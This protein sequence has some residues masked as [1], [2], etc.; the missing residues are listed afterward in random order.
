MQEVS[1][2][3]FSVTNMATRKKAAAPETQ[4]KLQPLSLKVPAATLA[5]A[6]EAAA[7]LWKD[8]PGLRPT[9]ADALRVAL[10]R[11]LDI[12]LL[13]EKKASSGG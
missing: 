7:K 8:Q 9:R 6:D 11:G 3:F 2:A 12:I 1:S 10:D 4:T 5:R 13:E